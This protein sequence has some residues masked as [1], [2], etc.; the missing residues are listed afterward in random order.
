MQKVGIVSAK[1]TPFGK[2]GGALSSIEAYDL[3]ARA[4]IA[5]L[6][7]SG[8]ADLIKS[9]TD[10]VYGGSVRNS[11]GNVTRVAALAAGI[12]E[13][14]PAATLDRQCASSLDALQVASALIQSEQADCILTGGVESASQCP[15][16][17][18]RPTRAYAYGEPQ[19]YTI[20]FST[21]EI[22]DPP[23]GETAELVA[24]DHNITREDMDAFTLNSHQKAAAGDFSDE[25]IPITIANRKQTITV[26]TD[27][28]VRGDGS[29]EALAKLKPVFRKDGRV[30]PGNASPLSDGA[31]ACLVA[32]EQFIQT[33]KLPTLA[34]IKDFCTVGLDPTRMGLGPAYAIPKLL[35]KANLKLD[36]IDLFEVNEAFAAQMLGCQAVYPLPVDRVNQQG[37][38]LA[39]GHPMG[40][41][42]ARLVMTLAYQLKRQ[43]L[44]R[45]IAAMC[46]A[47]GQG[48]AILIET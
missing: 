17:F 16:L 5:T 33:H 27:E 8:H 34:W 7:A 42:G 15:W 1:R 36:D 4:F 10:H 43:N 37:G 19:P 24:D 41:S 18:E 26:D 11:I 38:A 31:A 2:L 13:V 22:G 28:S 32:G 35:E 29:L 25:I 40:A 45:G 48:M 20:R 21:P 46:A 12:P 23:M 6:D 14:V 30:T 3:L 9:K 39:I 44:K 47:G